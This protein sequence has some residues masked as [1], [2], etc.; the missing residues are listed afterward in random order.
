MVILVRHIRLLQWFSIT[1]KFTD[2]I[3]RNTNTNI[4]WSAGPILPNIR[5]EVKFSAAVRNLSVVSAQGTDP[6]NSSVNQNLISKF[7]AYP[8]EE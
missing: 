1:N 5:P 6:V 3:L 7:N 2:L 4:M 8:V